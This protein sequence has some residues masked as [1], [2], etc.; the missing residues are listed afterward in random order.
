MSLS[1]KRRPVLSA[2]LDAGEMIVVS[3]LARGIDSYAHRGALRSGGRTI[4][5][6]GNGLSSVYP[7][8]HESLAEEIVQSGAVVSELPVDVGPDAKNFPRRNRIIAGSR[9]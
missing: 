5:V 2:P 9:Q 6:L 7:L 1:G 4:A 8:E 3:G